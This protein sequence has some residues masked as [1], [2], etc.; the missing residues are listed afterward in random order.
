MDAGHLIEDLRSQARLDLRGVS[1]RQFAGQR[2]RPARR[3]LKE[4][5][6]GLLALG[7]VHR[8]HLR[9]QRR[10]EDHV[11]HRHAARYRRGVAEVLVIQGRRILGRRA[12]EPGRVAAGVVPERAKGLLQ[13]RHVGPALTR[14]YVPPCGY[15]AGECEQRLAVYLSKLLAAGDRLAGRHVQPRYVHRPRRAAAGGRTTGRGSG[16][17][18]GRIRLRGG[19]VHV[20]LRRRVHDA[21]HLDRRGED[22]GDD[23]RRG[24]RR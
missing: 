10:Q 8:D 11:R 23:L 15:E 7:A 18:R 24:H 16:S 14:R 13:F 22:L 2:Q 6:A 3:E 5:L 17:L 1:R 12:E 9:G 21:A 20:V 4:G 19:R